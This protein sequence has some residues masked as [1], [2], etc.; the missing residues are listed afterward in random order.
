MANGVASM[1]VTPTV[2]ESHAAVTVNGQTVIS[3][4]PSQSLSLNVGANTIT[5][6]VTAQDATTRTYTVTVTRSGPGVTIGAVSP[7]TG[8][9]TGGTPITI[10]GVSFTGALSVTIG[11]NTAAFTVTDGTHIAATTPAGAAGPRDVAV[12]TPA[13]SATLTGGF[14]Y[15]APSVGGGSGVGGGGGGGGAVPTGPGITSLAPYI[16]SDGLFSLAATAASDDGKAK[17]S[18]GRG[19]LAKATDGSALRSVSI[20]PVASPPAPPADSQIIG[21]AY[22][23][24]PAGA[25]FNPAVTLTLT[26]DPAKLPAG[27]DEKNLV[28]ATWDAAAGKWIELPTTVDPVAHTL[29]VTIGHLSTFAVVAHTRAA[30][31]SI[32]DLSISPAEVPGGGQ[33]SIGASVRNTGDLGG[34]YTVEL[35]VN[36]QAESKQTVTVGGNAAQPVSFTVVRDTPGSYEVSVGGLSGVFK[37]AAPPASAAV[38]KLKSLTVEPGIVNLGQDVIISVVVDNTG[39]TAGTGPIVL[40]VD[41]ALVETREVVLAPGASQKVG[42]TYSGQPAGVRKVNVNGLDGAFTVRP[43]ARPRTSSPINWWLV[44]GIIAVIVLAATLVTL[45][46]RRRALDI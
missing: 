12:T 8:P 11:G 24:G 45:T 20:Q 2:S 10:T 35:K 39:G 41:G 46:V 30:S 22:E 13:G 31:F 28:M 40:K 25:T 21:L 23:L 26:Y 38:F 15:V 43:L 42:F 33:V 4:S 3:G 1:T 16:T 14:T 29:S 19:V 18:I 6:V 17:L 32:A 27:L 34:T 5:I 36:G 9:T 7:S 44:G 37:V